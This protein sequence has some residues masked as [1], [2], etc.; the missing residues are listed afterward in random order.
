AAAPEVAIAGDDVAY[1]MYTS[2]STG[3]PK[4]TAVRHRNVVNFFAGMDERVG[5]GAS[6]VVL[7]VTS[8]SFDI[9]V[10]ELLWPLTR[11]A[12]VV[13]AGEGLVNNLVPSAGGATRACSFSLFFF[14]AASSAA[15]LGAGTPTALPV[16]RGA[17]PPVGSS[18][19]NRAGYQ[20]V[21]DA[22]RFADR[23][24]F[25]AVWTPE[26]HFHPFGGLYPNPSVMAAA[27]AT[28]TSR[29]ALRSG[30]VVAPL[31]DAVRLAEEWSVVD[32]LSNGR[33]GLAFASG[34]NSNDF[35]L[36]PARFADR[37]QVMNEQLA[38]FRRLW[39]GETVRRINGTG[40]DIDVRIF[41]PPVQ[42]EPPIWLT[43]VG[44]IDTFQ[45]AGAVGAN[46]LTHLL[47]QSPADLEPKIRAYRETRAAHGHAGPGRV[48]LMIHAFMQADAGAAKQRAR[49]PFRDYLRSS[50]ELWRT[51][52]AITGQ[53]FPTSGAPEQLEAVIE[54]AIERYFETSGLF[55]SPETCADLVRELAGAGVDELACLIDF[56]IEPGEALDSLVSVDELRRAHRDEVADRQHSFT[57]LC[58]RHGVTLLQGTPSLM[59]AITAEPLALDALRGARALLVGGEA[60]PVGLAERLAEALPATRIVNMYGP[61]ETTIWSTT[62]ELDRARDL[63]G[64]TISIGR[65]IANT[66]LQ[67]TD[68]HGRPVPVSVPGELWIGG[69]GVAVGYLG[70]PELT[71]ERFVE[72]AG[73]GRFYR[74]GDRTLWRGDGT[75]DFLGR[76][77]RQVKILGHRVEPDEIESVLSRH[78]EIESVAV[79]ARS[80][81]SGTELVAYVSPARVVAT[82]PGVEGSFVRR[83]GELWQ[84]TY[85]G[86]QASGA[87]FAGW[88]SSYDGLPI[89]PDQMREWLTHTVARIRGLR[90]RTVADIGV[91]VGL[92]LRELAAHT[93]RYYGVDISPAALAAAADCLG[94]DRSLP[95]HVHLEHSGPEYLASLPARSVD[96]VVLNS[97]VQYFPSVGYLRKVVGD[98]VRVVAPGG[99]IYVGD[100]RALEML[101]EFHTAVQLHRAQP[102]QTIEELRSAVA[103]QLQDE[104][105][106]CISPQFFRGLAAELPEIREVRIE[107]KRGRADNE[108]TQFRYDVSLI[109][110]EPGGAPRALPRIDFVECRGG[111]DELRER[112][113]ASAAPLLVT[114]IPNRRLWR[115]AR[116]SQLLREMPHKATA[117]D[118]DRGL[119]EIDD[120]ATIH[121]EDVLGMASS[122]AREA[123]VIVP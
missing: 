109:V 9:S 47:G 31:H 5:C 103:R 15:R 25:E 114:G 89:P 56:G 20:L 33:V 79:V 77:D 54:L 72:L 46:V 40:Q 19:S 4:G 59:T 10:L 53:E 99:A 118:L 108:L 71:A 58:A 28:I 1:L 111:L 24:G 51:L 50:V 12:K 104:R 3:R 75:V 84:D 64:A 7:A 22:A 27:L 87:E 41:P 78:P 30:S 112:L 80:G 93:T 107:L 32:N 74:T 52:F 55:G 115:V 91:G 97:V 102:L 101:P 42:P 113:A 57:E 117:W 73:Q 90:P 39:R 66:V 86:S 36:A 121:P 67:I 69:D 13:V 49:G 38:D 76:M 2:G 94:P 17:E 60:F 116:A 61:T 68:T 120:G 37:K 88:T 98:A 21:L 95:S 81:A 8:V 82:D 70:Q 92:V 26:R 119:W 14:A 18:C 96:V 44:S 34:W 45:R 43:S 65:P 106:L 29:V 48:T 35:V 105:E 16:G 122:V 123:Q 83:W 6:D 110:G 63:D 23:H 11:G 85:A 100:V 62:H